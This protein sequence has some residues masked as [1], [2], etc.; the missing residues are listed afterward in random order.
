MKTLLRLLSSITVYCLI[1]VDSQVVDSQ[2]II[3][4]NLQQVEDATVQ[5]VDNASL[6]LS[7]G[8]TFHWDQILKANVRDPWQQEIETRIETIGL[9][10][11]RLKRR[12]SM[13]DT[14]GAYRIARE[15]YLN[16]ERAFENSEEQFLVCYAVMMGRINEGA[17]ASAVDPMIRAIQ[18]Q[19]DCS[20]AF[21]DRFKHVTFQPHELK[22][23]IYDRL[24]PIWSKP[25]ETAMQLEHLQRQH[26]LETLV[27]TYPGIAV[28]LSS[29]AAQ[30]GQ[31]ELMRD[32][33]V[34]MGS[35][36]ELRAW[37]R[38]LAS[39]LSR[40]PL[41]RLIDGSEGSIRVVTMHWWATATDQQ[42]SKRKR[43][44]TLLKIAAYYSQQFPDLAKRSM[45]EA[46]K[47]TDDPEEQIVLGKE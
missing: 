5:G 17:F 22:T 25:N 16:E 39:D 37:Q 6:R 7:D 19:G 32:W 13:N 8:R 35:V 10:L 38:V 4:R 12:L 31:R 14:P 3:L 42:A 1:C 44:L 40:T 24:L 21:L 18:I 33:N 15:W 36:P 2:V 30:T 47:L 34:A 29:M 46:A 27:K 43:M 11:Y 26:D 28:Y 23:A 45:L 41:R 20:Q 9:P